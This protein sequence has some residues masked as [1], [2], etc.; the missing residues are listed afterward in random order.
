MEMCEEA[1]AV[2]V[3]VGIRSD[4]SR[5]RWVFDKGQC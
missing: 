5:R 1:S 4:S 3:D 2:V